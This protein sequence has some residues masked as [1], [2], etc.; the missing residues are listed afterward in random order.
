MV[1]SEKRKGPPIRVSADRCTGC[2]ICQLRCSLRFEKEFNPA[3]AKINIIRR[4]DGTAEYE[5]S[6]DPE[7]DNCGICVRYCPYEAL[8]REKG[9]ETL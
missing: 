3:R 5:I 6:F 4:V 8:T 7:C 2:M 9:K 1:K